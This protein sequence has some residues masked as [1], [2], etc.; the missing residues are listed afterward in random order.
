MGLLGPA[1]CKLFSVILLHL[2]HSTCWK[3]DTAWN[4]STHTCTYLYQTACALYDAPEDGCI[5]H[6]KH[7]EWKRCN[8]VTL[9]NL[10]QAGPSKPIYNDAWKQKLNS[11]IYN[12]YLFSETC[13][14]DYY[15]RLLVRQS[16]NL[17][18][19]TVIYGF[20]YIAVYSR[21]SDIITKRILRSEFF[22]S[23]RWR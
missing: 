17:Q 21:T 2:F 3:L 14:S 5:L 15:S 9:N 8:K 16:C 23:K 7:V 13:C 12:L 19:E 11:D 1:W 4:G 20:F 10:H 22:Q 18:L 6:L